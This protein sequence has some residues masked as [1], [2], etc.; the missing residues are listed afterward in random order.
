[1]SESTAEIIVSG[2][3]LVTKEEARKQ[4]DYWTDR[5]NLRHSS[6]FDEM[7]D[8]LIEIRLRKQKQ[9]IFR[10][11]ITEFEDKLKNVPGVLG[12]DPYP[13]EHAFADGLYIRKLTVP[14]DT[15]TVTKIHAVNHAFFLQK[16]TISVLTEDGVKKFTAPYQGITKAG[17]KRII[18]HHDE[19][20]FSTVHSTKE[21]DINKIEVEVI[22]EDFEWLN[23]KL[24][25]EKVIEFLEILKSEE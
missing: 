11:N 9:D 1:M 22:A 6:T 18:Y 13:L 4:F 25:A 21:T 8:A 7:Y 16:G 15:L 24:E 5:L 3:G 2:N 23:N 12:A 10:K 20:I 17:T 14:A 19:V